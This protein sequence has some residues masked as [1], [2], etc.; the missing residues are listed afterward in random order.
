MRKQPAVEKTTEKNKLMK[1]R[2]SKL[3]KRFINSSKELY[4]DTIIREFD[5]GSG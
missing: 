3:K 5:P 1:L 4:I 2:K